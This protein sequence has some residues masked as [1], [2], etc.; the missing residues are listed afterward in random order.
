MTILSLDL[1]TY[2]NADISATG[3]YRYVDDSNFQIL[4]LAYAFDDDPVQVV[5][6]AQGEHI[7]I[8]IVEAIHDTTI[9]K[10]AFNANFE[11]LCFSRYLNYED[12]YLS[13][14]GWYCTMVQALNLGLPGSLKSVGEVLGLAED[15]K[16][17]ATG[18]ALIKYF[19]CPCK[20]T[21]VNGG[22]IRNLPEHA[23]E[24]WEL[25]KEYNGQD[26]EAE[27]AIRKKIEFFKQPIEERQ[28]WCL[29][30][31][32]ND[33]GVKIDLDLVNN[34]IA[35][36]EQHKTRT[37][38]ESVQLTGLDNPNSGAQLKDW[39]RTA[40]GIDVTSL[41]KDTV[42]GIIEQTDNET[43]KRVLGLRQELSK[44]S[45]KKYAAMQNALCQDGR[46]RGLL[47][48]YGANR[49][50]RW[51]GRLV[52]VQNLPQN[53]LPDLDVARNILKSGDYDWLE[54]LYGDVQSVLSQLIRTAFTPADG[55]R[56]MVADF[57]AIEARVIAWMA[58]EQ[59]RLEVFA[60]HGKIYEAS[61]ATMFHVPVESIDKHSPLRQKGKVAE[62]ALGYQG[63]P[64]AMERMGALKMG[65]NEDELQ[66]I[67]TAWRKA[68]P[69]IVKLWKNVEEAAIKAITK[70][71]RV[72]V[73]KGLS[74]EYA[75]G[76][77]LAH[78]PSGRCLAYCKPRLEANKFGR[79]A[80]HYDGMN[81][82]TKQWTK[83]STYGGK[84][85][86]NAVQAI[87]RDCLRDAMIR[88]DD[89]GYKTV[90]HVHDE[91]IADM[92]DDV[93]SLDDMYDIMGQPVKWA[94]GL[95]LKADGFEH[96]YYRKDG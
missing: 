30:Q 20:P 29:D 65:L 61:A 21:K 54:F 95:L 33:R 48:F 6:L 59:W 72:E 52:Q 74:Y 56:F 9:M 67:V 53:H 92:P 91:V 39:L 66:P 13:P 75:R 80:I 84:L 36:D 43:V 77:L 86:E 96:G 18:K 8:E 38:A 12:G 31:Q 15:K 44:T 2:S 41:T 49:T 7:P 51:A 90:M 5:D 82:E 16:K 37:F 57:S 46:V 3:A 10:A 81:Q 73:T 19:C 60:T 89:A 88:L 42:P 28:L 68:N 35:C 23:P 1:E 17:L 27:R 50:G 26:V 69:A 40:A 83:L 76:L 70:R 93:G 71:T 34:A 22:R 4:L 85:V 25:F 32:I 63:G 79:E 78:L 47:Q 64:K 24:K 87:A 45:V 94:P 58:G 55:H 11:R 14:E 62:L